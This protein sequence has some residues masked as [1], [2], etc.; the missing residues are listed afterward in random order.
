MLAIKGHELGLQMYVLSPSKED[1][2]AQVTSHWICGDPSKAPALKKFLSLVDIAT[3]ENEFLDGELLQ[4]MSK[5]SRTPI[6]PKPLTMSKIQ[7]RLTQKQSLQKSELPHTVFYKVDN[8]DDLLKTWEKLK[9]TGMVLKQRRFGYDGHGTLIIRSDRDFKSLNQTNILK[10]TE[11]AGDTPPVSS[12][13][14]DHL[15]YRHKDGFIAEAFQNF[16]RELALLTA[17]NRRG[18]VCFFPLV[19]TLQKKAQCF[20]VKGPTKHKKLTSLKKKITTYLEKNHY[21]GVMAFELFDMGRDLLVNEVAPR[22]HN[23]AHY[24]LDAL[25]PDQFTIHLLSILNQT[26]PPNP[27]ELASGY[28]MVN[29]LGQTG[30]LPKW[31]ISPNIKIHWYGKTQNRIGRK[32]GHIN[33][34]GP[35]ANRALNKLLESYGNFQ[36]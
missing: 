9:K 8:S 3:F 33:T 35:S 23:S 20:W 7:D 19:E 18:E 17:R 25:T 36:L 4:K 26:L 32:M 13:Q 24:S 1:P 11:F 10:A 27:L 2:A 29:L 21:E 15:G 5:E 14:C 6:R 34:T 22:V 31:S 30:K 12:D 28:A 16:K